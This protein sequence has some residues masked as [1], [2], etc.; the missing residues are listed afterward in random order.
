[1][2]KEDI[3]WTREQDDYLLCKGMDSGWISEN[4]YSQHNMILSGIM[5]GL[6]TE[7]CSLV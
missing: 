1:M 6:E 5:K 7:S 4:F 2:F 3:S